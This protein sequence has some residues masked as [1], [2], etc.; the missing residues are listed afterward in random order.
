MFPIGDEPINGVYPFIRWCLIDI[1]VVTKQTQ[2]RLVT[3]Q[4]QK[5]WAVSLRRVEGDGGN[6]NYLYITKTTRRL[7]K[8]LLH[9][10]ETY[11]VL[12]ILVSVQDKYLSVVIFALSSYLSDLCHNQQQ[13]RALNVEHQ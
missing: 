6:T 2:T 3:K 9:V 10:P 13:R 8:L 7:V 1:E 12:L 4:T 5:L 11:R